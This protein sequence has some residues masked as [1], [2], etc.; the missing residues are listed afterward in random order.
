LVGGQSVRLVAEWWVR[1]SASGGGSGD[2][3]AARL[4]DVE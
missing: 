1:P 2:E 3:P 4:R